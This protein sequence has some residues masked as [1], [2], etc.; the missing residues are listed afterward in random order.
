MGNKF[1]AI[2]LSAGNRYGTTPNASLIDFST[3]SFSVDL[4]VKSAAAGPL[5]NKYDNAALKGYKLEL[6]SDGTAKATL[7]STAITAGSSLLDNAWHHLELNVDRSA[8]SGVLYA[9]G[10]AGTSVDLTSLGS[11]A[12]SAAFKFGIDPTLATYLTGF[13]SEIRLSSGVRHSAAFTP[14]IF[15][16]QDDTRT[17]LLY[18]F[19]EGKGA[20]IY[21]MSATNI[22]LYDP[23]TRHTATLVGGTG[24][25]AFGPVFASPEDIIQEALWYALDTWTD[26][27]VGYVRSPLVVYG[28]PIQLKRFRGRRDDPATGRQSGSG[29]TRGD[30]PC[31]FLTPI[32][33]GNLQPKTAGFD[34]YTIPIFLG[35]AIFNGTR[36]DMNNM[37][38]ACFRAIAAAETNNDGTMPDAGSFFHQQVQKWEATKPRIFG[39][40][41]Q[42][43]KGYI[44]GFGAILR[45]VVRTDY[46][47]AGSP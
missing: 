44:G 5:V 18:H 28:R 17:R 25:W 41:E 36:S 6:L 3:D 15:A 19:W 20:T 1:G 39:V 46:R 32:D 14:E 2:D 31:I 35:G 30:C 34:D 24:T 45:F 16:H 10:V 26:N 7:N 27:V 12:N 4:W 37:F 23:G 11:I 38:W 42:E 9:G 43:G 33:S 40:K 21:D 8:N 29:L 47:M 22:D 13:L